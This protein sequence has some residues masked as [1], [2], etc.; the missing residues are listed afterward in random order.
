MLSFKL[1]LKG[2]YLQHRK[3]IEHYVTFIRKTNIFFS[4]I[5]VNDLLEENN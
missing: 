3:Q 4:F 2:N 5:T 1:I